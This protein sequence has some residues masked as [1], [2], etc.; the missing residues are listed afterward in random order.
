MYVT[1]MACILFHEA[2][3]A[4]EILR[5]GTPLARG[6]DLVPDVTEVKERDFRSSQIHAVLVQSID[7]IQAPTFKPNSPCIASL[8]ETVPDAGAVEPEDADEAKRRSNRWNL[9][10]DRRQILRLLEEAFA[11]QEVRATYATYATFATWC[12]P[13]AT[14]HRPHATRHT[15]M[16]PPTLMS[17][18]AEPFEEAVESTSSSWG[19][20]PRI[21]P[22]SKADETD[23]T[24]SPTSH[25]AEEAAVMRILALGRGC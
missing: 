1:R 7:P 10:K 22:S 20:W 3:D 21:W 8:S 15:S 17:Q 25:D 6:E 14:C 9:W 18:E 24:D 5:G 12:K 4:R 16:C 2:P 19:W 11:R 23:E 13:H